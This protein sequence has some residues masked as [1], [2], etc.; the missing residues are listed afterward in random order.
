[1]TALL[2]IADEKQHGRV[3]IFGLLQQDMRKRGE[4]GRN[5]KSAARP[6]LKRTSTD[7]DW[8]TA[9]ILSLSKASFGSVK[10]RNE[11]LIVVLSITLVI[12]YQ[13]IDHF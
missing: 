13:A 1:M 8:L 7:M 3:G 2:L 12:T 6:R 11:T 10:L 4:T 5:N 9:V